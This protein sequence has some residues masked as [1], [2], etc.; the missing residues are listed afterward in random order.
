MG[1]LLRFNQHGIGG[2]PKARS[3]GLTHLLPGRAHRRG[4]PAGV[5]T[6][7][8]K[9]LVAALYYGRFLVLMISYYSQTGASPP[10]RN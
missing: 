9:V 10:A 8:D 3:S 5:T 4:T 1:I 7:D 2:A 6:G